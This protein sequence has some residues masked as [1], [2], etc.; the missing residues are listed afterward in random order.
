[1][2]RLKGTRPNCRCLRLAK[3]PDRSAAD[4]CRRHA[5][6]ALTWRRRVA[7]FVDRAVA[8]IV[9]ENTDQKPGAQNVAPLNGRK[10]RKKVIAPGLTVEDLAVRLAHDD[11]GRRKGMRY[12]D[13]VLRELEQ[14]HRMKP[15]QPAN[16]KGAR[17]KKKSWT[18]P[19]TLDQM[20]RE[21]QR[22]YQEAVEADEAYEKYKAAHPYLSRADAV[23][24]RLKA[25]HGV[26]KLSD[27]DD[28]VLAEWMSARAFDEPHTGAVAVPAE[29]AVMVQAVNRYLAE[30]DAKAAR[31][32]KPL[33][34][35]T[36]R[37]IDA[38]L[39][40]EHRIINPCLPGESLKDAA[41]R[42]TTQHQNLA[43][44]RKELSAAAARRT[45]VEKDI[46]KRTGAKKI[47]R[48]TVPAREYGYWL[49]AKGHHESAR[50]RLE[51]HLAEVRAISV[52]TARPFADIR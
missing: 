5:Q 22:R 44:M 47:T 7:E 28:D 26:E 8:R 42:V 41:K 43:A 19:L 31:R 49:A 6:N 1:M 35:M 39:L 45:E 24:A 15:D 13:K 33:V 48:M 10:V 18:A 40:R 32:K 23:E 12:A 51:H 14:A 27:L 16:A 21:A 4:R 52:L 37:T 46:L 34:K 30:R 9:G 50:K 2:C 17:S 25:E 11:Y 20:P 3:G 29:H 36:A 38:G